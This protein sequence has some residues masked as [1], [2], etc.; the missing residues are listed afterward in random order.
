M[1]RASFTVGTT[2]A[3]VL[4]ADIRLEVL[5]SKLLESDGGYS[6]DSLITGVRDRD[7]RE[8][9]TPSSKIHERVAALEEL[10]EFISSAVNCYNE[11]GAFPDLLSQ[12]KNDRSQD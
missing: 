8:Y 9:M 7:L 10:A 1:I 4:S 2:R 12:A 5:E 11:T 6:G 3:S